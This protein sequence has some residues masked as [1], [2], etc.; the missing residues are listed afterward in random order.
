MERAAKTAPAQLREY[1]PDKLVLGE[2]KKNIA[3]KDD[4][5]YF[6]R[7]TSHA[8]EPDAFTFVPT[9]N[10]ITTKLDLIRAQEGVER[11][12]AARAKRADE[13]RKEGNTNATKTELKRQSLDPIDYN[14]LNKS[15]KD[16]KKFIKLI[17]RLDTDADRDRKSELYKKNYLKAAENELGKR[18]ARKLADAIRGM[19]GQ[20]VYDAVFADPLLHIDTIYFSSYYEQQMFL[21]RILATWEKYG[22]DSNS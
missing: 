13:A 12:N 3:S 21:N 6:M 9:E 14:P 1:L 22:Y 18:A 4:L 2:V 5:E 17:S 10:S 20:E 7:A 15:N 11:V 16:I 19:T 8:A